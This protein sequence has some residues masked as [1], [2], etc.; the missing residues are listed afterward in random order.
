VTVLDGAARP[1]RNEVLLLGAIL[2]AALLLRIVPLTYSH[3]WDE[4]VYL[5]HA[6]VIVDGR[7]NYSEFDY[8]APLLSFLYAAGYLVWD[9]IYVA[10]F[11]QGMASTLAVLFAFLYVRRAFGGVPAL[12]AAALFAFA[13]YFVERSHELMSDMPAIALMVGAMWLF[14]RRSTRSAFM[15]GVSSSLAALMHFTSLFVFV[16]FAAD[17]FFSGLRVRR[18]LWLIVGAT[19]AMAP[20]LIWARWNYGSFFHTFALA[21]RITTEWTAPVP[22]S[23]YMAAIREIFPASVL[24]LF[25]CGLVATFLEWSQADRAGHGAGPASVVAKLDPRTERVL[26]LLAWGGAFFVYMARIPHKEVRYL[27]PICIPVVI[28]G[29]L[30]AAA[31]GRW[32]SARAMALK[33]VG[34]VLALAVG[35]FDFGPAF[36]RLTQPW[37]DASEW[38]TVQIAH[39]IRSISTQEDTVYAAHEFPVLAF[40]SE[41]KTKSLLPI[42]DDF[43]LAWHDW[44]NG[45]GYVVYYRPSSI[46][47]THSR[48]PSF[49]PDP[50]FMADRPNFHIVR[51]FPEAIVYRYD[52]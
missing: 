30:G 4:A 8:K 38:P 50:S 20:Y 27:L 45:A 7:T 13:P 18:L 36:S 2:L 42:Q 22:A 34:A 15:A 29:A 21:S 11:V 25:A 41:R 26:A 46:K 35:A 28:V 1:T 51:E 3:F 52:P 48:N 17:A 14:D 37:I 10:N 32:L 6:R 44:M 47:E 39:Y 43:D 24:A 19:I 23:F 33:M 9:N 12:I 40:Y 16:Y 31:I 49:K 5:Q